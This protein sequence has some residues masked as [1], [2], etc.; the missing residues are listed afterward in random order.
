MF[1]KSTLVGIAI[2]FM[3]TMLLAA[4]G[5]GSNSSSNS[6]SSNSGSSNTEETSSD[7]GSSS[8]S[9]GSSDKSSSSESSSG[10][11]K[12]GK[13]KIEIPYVAW[14]GCIPRTYVLAK[15]LEKAGYKVKPKQVNAGAMWT[16]VASHATTVTACAWLPTTHS[17]YW[18]DYKD[19]VKKVGGSVIDKAP[20][21]LTV[22]S[23]VK[24]DSIK[25]LKTNKKFGKAVNYKITGIDAGA[26]IMASTKKAIKKYGLDKWTLQSSSGG[27]MTAALKGAIAKKEPIVVTLWKPHFAFA[28]WDLKMLK[29]PKKVYG[30]SGD[31]IYIVANK[32]LKETSPGAYKILKQFTS[33]YDQ[34][35]PLMA[36]IHKGK[37][38]EKV[39][40]NFVKSHPDLVSKW[41]KGVATK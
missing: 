20:L 10:K 40:S 38:P 15:V 30:G 31:A 32:K 21:A 13:K 22:P 23:Y 3:L 25:D 17:A 24:I 11:V 26:G 5:S 7:S 19:T 27:A 8:N 12:L 28:K 37:D 18:K 9:S 4:C 6:S 36:A 1:K 16:A 2:V 41:T 34:L 35:N 33:S 29:D 39:A 14:A